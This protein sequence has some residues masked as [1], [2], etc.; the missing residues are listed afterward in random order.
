MEKKLVSVVIPTYNT[1]VKLF[2]KCIDSII[3]QD[4]ENKEIIIIDD[5]SKSGFASKLDDFARLYRNII[6]IHQ[7]NAGEGAAR[8]SGIENCHGDYVIFVDADD[9][10]ASGWISYAVACSEKYEADIVAGKVIRVSDVPGTAEISESGTSECLIKRQ[11]LWKVQRDFFYFKTAAVSDLE[12]LDPGV[13]SKLIRKR[14]IEHLRFPIGIK[15][16]SDQVFNHG[17]LRNCN[18]YVITNRLSYYYVMN[19]TSIS[20]VYQPKAVD[21]MMHS[22]SLIGPLVYNVE[23]VRQA[24]YYRVLSEI[25]QA[26]QY[27]Y[28]SDKVRIS[29]RQKVKGVR[30]ACKNKLVRECLGKM[31]IEMLPAI[32]WKLK[33]I[34]LKHNKAAT[35]VMLKILSDRFD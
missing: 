28:F 26:I 13:C 29:L 35:F 8:N 2:L 34:L 17:M 33:A 14:C 15:L 25:T 27:A 21:Y 7:K 12:V 20:H 16:S 6:V 23:E 11:D 5:G 4:Y 18:S 31:K 1:T 22:M 3:N 9:G 19:E 10:L 24:Y 32:Q 30:Y